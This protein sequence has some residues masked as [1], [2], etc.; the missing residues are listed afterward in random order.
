MIRQYGVLAYEA[1][2]G[3]EPRFLLITSRSSKRWIIPRGNPI[4]GLP[5]PQSAAQEA[6]EEAGV[7]GLVGPREIGA[8]KY[9]KIRRDGSSTTANVHV[10]PLHVRKQSKYWPERKQRET[11]W[12]TREEAAEMV[13][14]PGL[15]DMIAAFAPPSPPPSEEPG[16]WTATPRLQPSSLLARAK[17]IY[18]RG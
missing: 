10:F 2:E 11:R 17:A 18:R 1:A 15:R 3:S 16:G 14:E 4:R 9:K 6:Y 7:R 12:F 8:Y 13:S 5:P